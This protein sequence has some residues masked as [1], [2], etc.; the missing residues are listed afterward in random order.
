MLADC[1]RRRAFALGLPGAD[2]D[3]V[4]GLPVVEFRDPLLGRRRWASLPYTDVCAPLAATRAAAEQLAGALEEARRAARVNRLQVR[5]SLPVEAAQRRTV[6]LRH[7]LELEPDPAAVF[8]RL[9]RAQAQR[10]IM[11]ARREGVTVRAAERV[12]D[13]DRIFYG[14]Q[15]ETRRRIGALIQPR[16]FYTLLWHRMLAAGHGVLLLAY[17]DGAPV[18]GAVFLRAG[19]IVTYKFGASLKSYWHTR[20]NALLF[21]TMIES[22]CLSGAT[23]L[24]YGRT[25][26]PH[27]SLRT[28]KRYWSTDESPL[29]H[30]I[31]TPAH[32]QSSRRVLKAKRASRWSP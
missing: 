8:R 4:A 23:E 24:G 27:E 6:G 26:L 25:E 9:H 30:T 5:S 11:R 29:V 12:D 7:T 21:W 3:L 13:L 17:H 14:L 1:Y 22:A 31:G 2:G 19:G 15:T 18:A 32:K 16:R 10:N 20:A 28:F